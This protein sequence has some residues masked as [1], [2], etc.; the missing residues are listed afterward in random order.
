ME[1]PLALSERFF[2]TAFL[3]IETKNRVRALGHAPYMRATACYMWTTA[4]LTSISINL[5]FIRISIIIK[6][7]II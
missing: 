5:P 6:N 7:A 1:N 4:Y 2:Q 3:T